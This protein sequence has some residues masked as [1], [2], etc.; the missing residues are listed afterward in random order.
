MARIL[1]QE[2]SRVNRRE[3]AGNLSVCKPF[4]R[5]QGRKGRRPSGSATTADLQRNRRLNRGEPVLR[6]VRSYGIA[7]TR[8]ES[9]GIGYMSPVASNQSEQGR[10][11]N[12]RVELVER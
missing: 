4:Q 9:W 5:I 1:R 3:G 7:R 10:A 11:L 12:R 6:P 8:L 2:F